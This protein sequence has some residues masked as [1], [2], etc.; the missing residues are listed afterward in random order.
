LERANSTTRSAAKESSTGVLQTTFD[1]LL[2]LLTSLKKNRPHYSNNKFISCCKMKFLKKKNERSRSGG[3]SDDGSQSPS[4]SL[5]RG[6]TIDSI[7]PANWDLSENHGEDLQLS[8]ID[9]DETTLCIHNPSTMCRTTVVSNMPIPVS[10]LKKLTSNRHSRGEL[11]FPGFHH[12]TSAPV[13]QHTAAITRSIA[14]DFSNLFA[15][16]P[17]AGRRSSNT[18]GIGIAGDGGGIYPTVEPSPHNF[19]A[20]DKAQVEAALMQLQKDSL[21]YFEVTTQELPKGCDACVG[22]VLDKIGS[23]AGQFVPGETQNSIGLDSLGIL[24]VN[25][26]VVH[27]SSLQ[28]SSESFSGNRRFEAFDEGDVIGCAVEISGSRRVF[29]TKNG[30]II[31]PPTKFADLEIKKALLC[32]AFGVKVTQGHSV[33]ASANFGLDCRRPFIW[34]FSAYLAYQCSNGHSPASQEASNS[35]GTPPPP[36]RSRHKKKG[37]SRQQSA[38][39]SGPALSRKIGSSPGE[40]TR[41][42]HG[43]ASPSANRQIRGNQPRPNADR[44]ALSLSP[45]TGL[46]QRNRRMGKRRGAPAIAM[47]R[48]DSEPD[49]ISISEFGD[50]ATSTHDLMSASTSRLDSEWQTNGSSSGFIPSSSGVLSLDFGAISEHERSYDPFAAPPEEGYSLS[51]GTEEEKNAMEDVSDAYIAPAGVLTPKDFETMRENASNLRSIS[52]DGVDADD[53]FIQTFLDCCKADKQSVAV[54]VDKAMLDESPNLMA[55]FELNEIIL[56]AIELGTKAI[57]VSKKKSFVEVEPT[58]QQ[59][60]NSNLDLDINGLIRKKDIFSLICILRAQSDQRLDAALALMEFAQDGERSREDD[61]S[62]RDE[63]RSSGGIHSLLQ[64]F[65]AQG[66]PYELRVVSG[67]AVAY[68]IPSLVKAS[69]G[70]GLK[71]M[72]CLRFLSVSRSVTP[73]GVSISQETMF[74]ASAMGVFSFWMNVLEPLLASQPFDDESAAENTN[75]QITTSPRFAAAG[76]IFDQGHERLELQ[77]L[78]EMTVSLIVQIQKHCDSEC[79]TASLPCDEDLSM[80]RYTNVEQV[81]TVDVARPIAVREGLLPILVDWIKSDDKDKKRPA[82]SALRYLTSIK[83]KYMAGWIHSQM[84]NE[85]ALSEVVK[86]ADDY[87]VGSDVRLAVA[88]ILS[89]LC[90]A[91]HTR[92]AVVEARCMFYL[93][94][95]LYDHTNPAS[96]EVA[97]FAGHA[98]TQLAAGAI[99]RASV[100]GGGDTE[101]LDFVSPDKRDSLIE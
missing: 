78:L 77:E 79:A 50:V 54:A 47:S 26:K 27:P 57:E 74:K 72:E 18:G 44:D 33:Q 76:G 46:F 87:N 1:H 55:L 88:Q 89:S 10:Q 51:G 58:R 91:P 82:V 25:G 65:R 75:L 30:K 81:C 94:G 35:S 67:M 3:R 13:H 49:D 31:V 63:I 83:D 73:N 39:E 96:E 5:T 22:V 71:I 86:L 40:T 7:M 37:I 62:L 41:Q 99:T 24:R 14:P 95:F 53:S 45:A 97:L 9:Q 61:C 93:I 12:Q 2:S 8:H 11:G 17:S 42:N 38:P 59:R 16:S 85:G 80:W 29:F 19:T 64:V 43:S 23:S 34:E 69:P 98:I 36:F 28:Q 100:F 15:A 68:V 92:A 52:G 56:E 66:T 32:P 101:I 84:V 60:R 6:E 4:S 90:V 48:R 70:V 20:P 21:Y